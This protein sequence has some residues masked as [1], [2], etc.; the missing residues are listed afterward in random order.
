MISFC[1]DISVFAHSIHK[2]RVVYNIWAKSFHSLST[3]IPTSA[4]FPGSLKNHPQ[5]SEN[6]SGPLKIYS[7]LPQIH[8]AGYPNHP[9]IYSAGYPQIIPGQVQK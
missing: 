2:N 1:Y 3:D 9:Q 6:H 7:E 8:S 4:R 5:K